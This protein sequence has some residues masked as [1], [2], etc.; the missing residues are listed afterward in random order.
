MIPVMQMTFLD[1]CHELLGDE[2][3]QAK[4]IIEQCHYLHSFPSGATKLFRY[5]SALIAYSIPANP[6]LANYL[7]WPEAKVWELSRL[8][9][10]DGHRK[11]LLTQAISISTEWLRRAEPNT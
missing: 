6:Y 8:W 3:N 7:L 11:N 10:P 4:S 1:D 2:R 5:E 9:A